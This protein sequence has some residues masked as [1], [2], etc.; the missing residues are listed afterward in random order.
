MYCTRQLFFEQG[1]IREHLTLGEVPKFLE[2]PRRAGVP[3]AYLGDSWIATYCRR[4]H[5]GGLRLGMPLMFA[6][7]GLAKGASD[8]TG[9]TDGSRGPRLDADAVTIYSDR[10]RALLSGIPLLMRLPDA[11]MRTFDAEVAT[12]AS[13]WAWLSSGRFMLIRANVIAL[14]A[15]DGSLQCNQ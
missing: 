15:T 8:H 2:H 6:R 4:L 14:T 10:S 3:V 7:W 11:P 1:G 5:K 9:R 12:A 13:R